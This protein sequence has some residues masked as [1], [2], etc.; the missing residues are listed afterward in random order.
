MPKAWAS[1]SRRSTLGPEDAL[2][3]RELLES[4][5]QPA[6]DGTY[7]LLVNHPA[8]PKPPSLQDLATQ[9][10]INRSSAHRHVSALERAGRLQRHGR[11]LYAVSPGD[12]TKEPIVEH[13]TPGPRTAVPA[14]APEALGRLDIA[15]HG[16]AVH[17]RQPFDR[18]QA[19]PPQPQ[20]QDF[21]YFEHGNLPKRHRRLL[22]R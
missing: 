13:E 7:E 5:A 22:A 16:L 17:P 6:A 10:G 4:F 20:S 15:P 3:E 9:L 12:P 21:S 11:R 18:P 14:P 2:V 1:A 19:L 8:G